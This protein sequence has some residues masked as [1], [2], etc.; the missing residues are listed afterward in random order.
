M[1]ECDCR[2][3]ESR[4]TLHSVAAHIKKISRIN[5]EDWDLHKIA[6]AL[7]IICCPEGNN[8][9]TQQVNRNIL[10]MCMHLM[11]ICQSTNATVFHSVVFNT[12]FEEA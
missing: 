10:W 9:A 5:T 1:F 8:A 6:V 2:V 11:E 12:T 7:K 3:N 4:N